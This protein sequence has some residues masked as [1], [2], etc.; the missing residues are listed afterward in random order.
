MPTV[1][2][3]GAAE[4]AMP[5]ALIDTGLLLDYLAGEPRAKRAIEPY[6]HR[7]ISVVTWLELMS[8]CTPALLEP[9]RG[10]LRSFERLS[11]S[12][13]IADEALRLMHQRS[14]LP[15]Q[16][17]LTWATA[18]VNQLRFVTAD[19]AHVNKDDT[20]VVLPYRRGKAPA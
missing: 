13:S 15:L 9:T 19:A 8:H 7:S 2:P 17:A 18:N 16:R 3:R 10:F 1:A 12:E 6:A 20:N 4:N 5:S 11:V 14:G